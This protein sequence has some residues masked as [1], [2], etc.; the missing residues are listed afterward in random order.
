MMGIAG[1][2]REYNS[3]SRTW[4]ERELLIAMNVYCKLPFGKLNH[5]NPLIIE[6]AERLDRTPSSVSMKLC[7]FA[8]FDPALQARG[9][10]G[11]T[12]A[13][14]T[15]RQVWD[16]FNADWERMSEKSEAAF[17]TLMQNTVSRT[18]PNVDAVPPV[19]PSE[20]ATTVKAR[21]HQTFFR[22]AVLSSYEYR[23]ALSGL[24]IPSLL[25]ASHIIPWSESESRRADPTNGICLNV[26]YD[27]AFD[28]K[29][30]TFDEE[31]R[32]VLSKTLK[33]KNRSEYVRIHFIAKEGQKL[34]LPHRFLPDPHALETHRAQFFAT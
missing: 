29:L 32:L 33:A 25:N 3:V 2:R 17:G 7:N 26:L 24:D 5:R 18:P 23:C 13:S 11:L 10:K 28:R 4:T 27:R 1:E 15:D 20:V 30:I 12:G 8:S 9:V 31:Y 21:R 16:A 14:R 34:C 19:G 22:N 6:V